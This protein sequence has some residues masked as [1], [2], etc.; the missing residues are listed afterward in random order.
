MSNS[1]IT[2]SIHLVSGKG[3]K[4]GMI[5]AHT[6]GLKNYGSYELQ[7]VLN[8]SPKFVG[9]I[10]NAVGELIQGGRVFH[11]K[12]EIEGLFRN[13]AKLLVYRTKDS[14]GE[15]ILRLIVPDSEFKYPDES[16]EFP[17]NKQFEDPYLR[18]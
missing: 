17:Y 10:L 1:S 7:C 5:D 3:L 4:E 12:D 2:W 8:F 15:D 14:C 11:D 18:N 16:E 9:Y 6:H 13:D